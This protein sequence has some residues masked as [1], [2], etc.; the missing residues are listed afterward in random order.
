MNLASFTMSQ[1]Y[2]EAS[3]H[4]GK[5]AVGLAHLALGSADLEVSG[6]GGDGSLQFVRLAWK[7]LDGSSRRDDEGKERRETKDKR[8]GKSSKLALAHSERGSL[9]RNRLLFNG[10]THTLYVS[11]NSRVLLFVG[12][13]VAQQRTAH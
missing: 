3:R 2:V 13:I 1:C 9:A 12:R 8:Y 10:R 11:R 4:K 5:V 7:G 6:L